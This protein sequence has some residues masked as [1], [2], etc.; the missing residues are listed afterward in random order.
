MQ[1]YRFVL[2]S[3]GNLLLRPGGVQGYRLLTTEL[4]QTKSL[5]DKHG[6]C[7]RDPWEKQAMQ[8]HREAN[9]LVTAVEAPKEDPN[10]TRLT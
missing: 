5:S 10:S 8:S 2:V 3:V 4:G 6:H 9:P 7:S 1:G